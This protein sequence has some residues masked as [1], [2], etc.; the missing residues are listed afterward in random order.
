MQYIYIYIYIYSI[1]NYIC[2]AVCYIP[3]TYFITG[4]FHLWCPS[5]ILLIPMQSFLQLSTKNTVI[6]ILWTRQLSCAR[7][8]WLFSLSGIW[9]F[10]THALQHTRRPCPSP[11][12]RACSN[13]CPLSQ[14]CH[15]TILSSVV[16]FSSCLQS[17]PASASFLQWIGSLYQVAKVLELQLQ[18][19]AFQWIFRIDFFK[20]WLVWSPGSPRDSQESSPT[21]Q[22]KTS[23]LW[24]WAFF[25]V[26][27]SHPY[28]TTGKT[29]ALTIRT[30][31]GK[32]FK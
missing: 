12:P 18:Y 28:M 23:I 32:V 22:F 11:S 26:Q 17:F 30:F 5:L 20:D 4:I 31:V 9:L 3:M 29:I 7:P 13:S 6:C 15:P 21:P 10:A 19:Q 24:H 25:M 2:H 16:P 1:I 27:L 8:H 14:W